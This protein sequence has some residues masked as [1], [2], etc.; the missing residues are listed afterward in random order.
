MCLRNLQYF[1][2][3]NSPTDILLL[4][5]E[6]IN[7]LR[8]AKTYTNKQLNH[9]IEKSL[10][11]NETQNNNQYFANEIFSNY[12]LNFIDNQSVIYANN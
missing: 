6:A 9:Q 8:S 10:T 2:T 5:F 7:Y 11:Q 4:Y 3:K 1:A 12:F